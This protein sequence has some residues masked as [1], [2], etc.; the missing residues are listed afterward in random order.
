MYLLCTGNSDKADTRFIAASDRLILLTNATMALTKVQKNWMDSFVKEKFDFDRFA[1]YIACL[2]KLLE[3]KQE[4]EVVSYVKLY[5]DKYG[6]NDP[7]VLD[8]KTVIGYIAR[9]SDSEDKVKR[10]LIRNMIRETNKLLEGEIKRL[11]IK[12]EEYTRISNEIA[13]MS[14][15]FIHAGEIS[16]NNVLDNYISEITDAISKSAEEYGEEMFDSIKQVILSAKD[17]DDVEEKITPYMERSWKFFAKEISSQISKDFD[18]INLKLTKRIEVD[19][20]D[21]IKNDDLLQG[22]MTY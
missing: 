17:I 18:A 16:A 1:I 15:D 9:K 3:E 11:G 12:T 10:C 5:F 20:E 2:D 7:T 8:E 6:L 22:K 4:E 13:E 21:W 19:V 14:T